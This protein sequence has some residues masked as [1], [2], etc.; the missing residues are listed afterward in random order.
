MYLHDNT[1]AATRGMLT[2]TWTGGVPTV[3]A[4]SGGSLVGGLEGWGDSWYR[5]WTAAS[6]IVAANT[7]Q[8]R[9]TPTQ[10]DGAATGNA[11]LFGALVTDGVHRVLY[12]TTVGA[13][14]TTVRRG[15]GVRVIRCSDEFANRVLAYETTATGQEIGI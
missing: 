4:G 8:L 13:A 10:V 2:I 12:N 6:N 7:N 1:A 14:E 15:R 9:I 3:A 11:L 5:Q